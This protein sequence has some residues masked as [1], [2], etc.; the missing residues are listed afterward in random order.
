VSVFALF[1][2]VSALLGGAAQTN[3]AAANSC[4]DALASCR[5]VRGHAGTSVQWGAWAEVGMAARGAARKRMEAMEVTLGF[6]RVGLA[7]GLAA[8]GAATRACAPSVL[9]MLPVVWSQFLQDSSAA[10]T[11]LAAFAPVGDEKPVMVAGVAPA[12][13]CAVSLVSILEMTRQMAGGEV[14]ADAPLMEAGVDSLGAVE[15]RNRLQIAAGRVATLPTTLVF[16]FPT[17]R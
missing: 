6:G 8:L 17:A 2:S 11:F 12:G 9:A 14:D 5:R 1:S 3:Y 4:L 15:L 13:V 16:D 7:Q 10:P